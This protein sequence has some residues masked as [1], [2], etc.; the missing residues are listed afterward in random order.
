MF[1]REQK[2]L[3]LNLRELRVE[4]SARFEH[5]YDWEIPSAIKVIKRVAFRENGAIFSE[6]SG[7]TPQLVQLLFGGGDNG[8]I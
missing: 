4:H 7:D 8:E 5:Y 2:L 6:H 1:R 3:N